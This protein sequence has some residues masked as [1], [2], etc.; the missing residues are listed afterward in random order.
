MSHTKSLPDRIRKARRRGIREPIALVLT[1]VSTYMLGFF[2]LASVRDAEINH[3]LQ[4]LAIAAPIGTLIVA[5]LAYFGAALLL[6]VLV[7]DVLARLVELCVRAALTARSL[8]E[9]RA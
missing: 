4:S 5:L 6:H 2:A 3:L 7:W 8:I 9:R 1:G